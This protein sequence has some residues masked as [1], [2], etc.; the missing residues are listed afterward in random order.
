METKPS[1]HI[2]ISIIHYGYSHQKY[3]LSLKLFNLRP[4]LY[5]VKQ[6]AVTLNIRRTFSKVLEEK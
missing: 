1:Q 6:K 3:T 4:G 5:T 2:I